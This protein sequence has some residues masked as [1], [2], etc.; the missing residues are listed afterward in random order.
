MNSSPPAD[1]ATLKDRRWSFFTFNLFWWLLGAMLMATRIS[2]NGWTAG[3]AGLF[4]LFLILQAQAVYGF[5]LAMTG[6][7]L[8]RH[9]GD[10]V[11]INQTLPPDAVPDKLPPVAIIMPIFN[12][13]VN[14]VF[15]GLRT[16]YESLQATGHGQTFDFFILSDSSDPNCWVA[17]EK[18][19]FDLCQQIQGFGHIFYRKRRL[20]QH[21]KSGNVA[22][23]CRRWGARYEYVVVLDADSIMTGPTFVRLASLMEHHPQVGIIQSFSRTVLGQTLFQR[24]NQFACNAY[25]PLFVAGANYWQGDNANFYGHNAILRSKPFMQYCAMPE[26]PPS[27]R[28][29]TRIL[30]HDTVEA[31]LI[32]R[33]G[34]EVWS[35]YDL[36]GSYEES[37]PDLLS[38]L[39]RDRRWC[40]GNLQHLWFLFSPGLTI[41]SRLNILNG[42]MAYAGS[43]MWLLFLLFSPVLFIGNTMPTDNKF[44][45]ACSMAL[46]LVPKILGALHMLS[47]PAWCAAA[48]GRV[49][50]L[51]S[52]LVETAY[53]MLLAPIQMLFYTQFVWSTF[54]GTSVGWGRQKRSEGDG[55]SWQQCI[56]AHLVHTVLAIVAGTLVA[57]LL[58]AMVPWMLLV[59]AG[60]VVAIPLS[61]IIASGKLG[62]FCRLH[63]WFLIPEETEPPAEL[64]AMQTPATGA[65]GRILA[66]PADDLGL[67]RA[68]LDPRLNALHV[69]LLRER[70][71][72]SLHTHAYLA[73]LCDR[74]L[75]QGP[76]AVDLS[77]KKVLMWDADAMQSLHQKLWGGLPGQC[78]VWWLAAFKDYR[79][80]F[81]PEPMNRK[82]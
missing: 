47:T 1:E 36:K 3:S 73:G 24:I 28:L 39:Q 8:L 74:L 11:R 42:I 68:I 9:G 7:W 77:E 23:F 5:S 13:D 75:L 55:P 46:L 38:S 72:V 27:G 52:V 26:L 60:P 51:L 62:A 66:E 49:K 59:L 34:F 6:W 20:A 19:W 48:G 70:K 31:A 41:P 64:R 78:N 29:G 37:P 58:P 12:E 63:G 43:P 33:A 69:S 30:S 79:D 65:D 22:D 21:H 76:G 2:A 4:V 57:W 17:E 53:S 40:H 15:Q 54:F 71:L 18:A 81:L 45:F 80:S 25:G 44:L 82:Y 14:R 10:P 50:I 56:A 16:M 67:V 35:D 61:H 32:R